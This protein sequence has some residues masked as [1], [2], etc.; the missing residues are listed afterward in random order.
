MR[1]AYALGR[2]G[3]DA[4][5]AV[6]SLIATISKASNDEELFAY[7]DALAKIGEPSIKPLINSLKDRNVPRKGVISALGKI[8]G[9]ALP[10]LMEASTDP[11]PSVRAGAIEALGQTA[12]RAD[13]AQLLIARLADD[14][15]NVRAAAARSLGNQRLR[16][17]DSI[18]ELEKTLSSGDGATKIAAL[19]SLSKLGLDR[20]R[21][22][23][24]LTNAL[25]TNDAALRRRSVE[26][27]QKMGDGAAPAASE[28]IKLVNDP[29][30]EFRRDVVNV[31]GNIG[32]ERADQIVPALNGKLKDSSADVRAAAAKGLGRM[33]SSARPA[34]QNLIAAMKDADGS[35]RAA[36]VDAFWRL[37]LPPQETTSHLVAALKDDEWP[38]RQAA[39]AGLERLGSRAVDA[40]P[41]L[42]KLLSSSEDRFAAFSAL[43]RIDK[44]LPS[45]VPALTL[46]LESD[47][48][49]EKAGAARMLAKIGKEAKDAL[50]KLEELAK[51]SDRRVRDAAEDAIK[52]IR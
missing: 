29:N 34:S 41:I 15:P 12:N 35:V 37:R 25:K 2:L 6:D 26:L 49:F 52:E 42:V 19:E 16:V 48:D 5:E 23:A 36:A 17:E 39:T 10:T 21:L 1:G 31:L 9:P 44:A 38:V 3:A 8:R 33:G 4:A 32:R 7:T 47:S 46:S 40:V 30:E 27:L 43:R 22:T 24:H 51:H 50:P 13:V 11:N 20:T 18:E 14:D 28:L 45:H